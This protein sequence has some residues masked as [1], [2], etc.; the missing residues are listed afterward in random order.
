M[1]D[2]KPVIGLVGVGDWGRHILRDLV[3]LGA[4]VHA[5]ANSEASIGRAK[6][7]GA[8]SIVDRIDDLPMSCD[9]YIVAWRTVSHL[10]AVEPLLARGRPIYVEKPLSIDI[11]RL[12]HL[13][14]AAHD[15]VFTM[16]KW[17]YH[18]GILELARIAASGEFGPVTGLRTFRLGWENHHRDVNAIWILLPHDM[19]IA[20]HIFG[21]VPAP[22]RAFRDPTVGGADGLIAHLVTGANIPVVMEVS[23]GHPNK[24]RSITL[25]CRD[26]ACVLDDARYDR[27]VIRRRDTLQTDEAEERTVAA[28]MPLKKEIEAF[29]EHLGGGPAPFT[30]LHEETAIVDAITHLQ[31]M[32]FRS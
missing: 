18:P 28:D 20:L 30:S 29:L 24:H 9:G 26:A 31:T 7:G 25:A 12:K 16:H 5:V 4:A 11:E 32:A 10:D 23:A 14:A 21:E 27:I 6:A 8:V 22:V 19:S 3:A 13:P 17:R 1:K 15:L 2:G